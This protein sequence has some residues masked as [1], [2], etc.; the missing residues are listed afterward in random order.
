MLTIVTIVSMIFHEAITLGLHDHSGEIMLFGTKFLV[1]AVCV[2]F[3]GLL[4]VCVVQ[5]TLLVLDSSRGKKQLP[6]AV[7]WAM[8][9]IFIIL[10]LFPIPGVIAT[11]AK[12]NSAYISILQTVKPVIQQL[13]EASVSYSPQKYTPSQVFKIIISARPATHQLDILV[14]NIRRGIFIYASV[15]G[16]ATVLYERKGTI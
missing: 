15:L 1:L 6:S 9:V 11:Y 8:N 14:Q 7:R 10:S 5:A 4:W 12:A 13:K 3:V 16:F 2:L